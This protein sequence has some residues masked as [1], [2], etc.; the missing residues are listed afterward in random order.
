MPEK[1]VRLKPKLARRTMPQA[2]ANKRMLILTDSAKL[3]FYHQHVIPLCV[4]KCS[5][6]EC[7]AYVPSSGRESPYSSIQSEHRN[8]VVEEP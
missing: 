3:Y 2:G 6:E 4:C 8:A 7:V 1:K 5:P